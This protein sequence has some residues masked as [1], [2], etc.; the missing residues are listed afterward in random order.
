MEGQILQASGETVQDGVICK[1]ILIECY[2][3]GTDTAG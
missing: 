3:G 2:H 1:G